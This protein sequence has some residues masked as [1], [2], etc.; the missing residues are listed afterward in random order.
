MTHQW[1]P[2]NEKTRPMKGIKY[3]LVSAALLWLCSCTSIENEM[4][5]ILGVRSGRAQPFSVNEDYAKGFAKRHMA[6]LYCTLE[7]DI[8]KNGKL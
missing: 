5:G 8:C 1:R 4:S 2:S 7:G 3:L 6:I